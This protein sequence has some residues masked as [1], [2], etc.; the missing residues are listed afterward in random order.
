[1]KLRKMPGFVAGTLLAGSVAAYAAENAATAAQALPDRTGANTAT[2]APAA[3][4]A[5]TRD[6]GRIA[7]EFAIFAG[8]QINARNL[9]TGLRQ[10]SEVTL[11]PVT[12]GG[13]V[14]ETIALTPP[15]RPMGNG[16]V[17]IALALAQEQLIRLGVTRPTADQL[18]AALVGGT[19]T[20]GPGSS[21]TTTQLR[22]VL[23]MRAQGMGWSQIA[24]AM[25]T[26][27]A[28]VMS[29]LKQTHEQIATG[30]RVPGAS[31]VLSAGTRTAMGGPA[32]AD[33]RSQAGGDVRG[34]GM[35]TGEE[36]AGNQASLA[37]QI[38]EQAH[39]NP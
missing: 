8:S 27:L 18:K 4:S 36:M 32:I 34:A 30:Q 25:G 17:R 24:G 3:G 29:G 39:A 6:D 12:G 1:M 16:D 5:M 26:K 9:V 23:A 22:G 10:G 13:Q 2:N 21:E 7:L 20:R 19:V 11:A 14:T 15:T 38:N 33:T 28:H 35:V 37:G 31:L